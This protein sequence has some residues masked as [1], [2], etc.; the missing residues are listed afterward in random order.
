MKTKNLVVLL[1]VALLLCAA[2]VITPYVP[3]YLGD[4]TKFLNSAGQWAVPGGS[5]TTSALAVSYAQTPAEILT[6]AGGTSTLTWANGSGYLVL[7]GAVTFAYTFPSSTNILTYELYVSNAQATN[8][9]FTFPSGTRVIGI[10]GQQLA[11]K[12]GH[13]TFRKVTGL[14]GSIISTNVYYGEAQ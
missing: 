3:A 5:A 1:P 6:H 13:L 8:C 9:A 7:T 2:T 12:F 11:G 4:T 14:D 10:A